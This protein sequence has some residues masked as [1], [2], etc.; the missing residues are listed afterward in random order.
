MS[1]QGPKASD[2]TWPEPLYLD[3]SALVKLLV[4]EPDSDTLNQA[5]V[6]AED[7]IISDLAL[8]EVA[9]ALGRRLRGR[10]L[11]PTEARRLHREAGAELH[12]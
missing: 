8:T 9:S 10:R 3:A 12:R 11:E 7:V 1:P 6:G 4:P 5:L 2:P